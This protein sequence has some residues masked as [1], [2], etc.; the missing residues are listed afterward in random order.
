MSEPIPF[1]EFIRRIRAGDAQAA[2]ELVRR[3]ERAIR[4]EVR[5]RLSDPRLR[6]LFDSMDVCQ[7]VLASFFV[8]AACGEYDLE[9]PE[10]LLR[11][12]VGMARNKLA[13]RARRERA[14]RRDYRRGEA[15]GPN[16]GPAPGPRPSQQLEAR[17]LLSAFRARLSAEER[18][19][20]DLRADGRSWEEVAA[21]LGGTPQ[22]RRKQL[23]R[24]V[25]RAAQE[26]GLDEVGDG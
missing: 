11:L 18:R 5:L 3:H 8:R 4:L 15:I 9:R 1:A 14:Q 25:E 24:A 19:L 12:L 16:T 6:R 17:E 26:L 22:A 21:E 20:A 13:F 7:S 10:H 2:E 23:A